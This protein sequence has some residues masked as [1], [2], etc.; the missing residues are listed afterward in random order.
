VVGGVAAGILVA[1]E[2]DW[3]DAKMLW[4]AVL[5]PLLDENVT[6]AIGA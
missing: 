2:T 4:D 5:W 6:S 3:F 1:L